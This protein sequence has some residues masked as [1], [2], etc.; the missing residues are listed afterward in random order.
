MNCGKRF[1]KL[2]SNNKSVCRKNQQRLE[3]VNVKPIVSYPRHWP[4]STDLLFDVIMFFNIATLLH[5]IATN[6]R[7]ANF[8]AKNSSLALL[9]EK[10]T[11]HV[12]NLSIGSAGFGVHNEKML[13]VQYYDV[14][15]IMAPTPIYPIPFDQ[16]IGF[17]NIFLSVDSF[18]A[19]E[20]QI[21]NAQTTKICPII[22]RKV[23]FLK[24]TLNYFCN[25][26]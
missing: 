4:L 17:R 21:S 11:R 10:G 23:I 20:H 22:T 5:L 25:S 26:N 13:A 12:E 6:R 9:Y 18:P 24:K 3:L 16:I 8:C 7:F 15:W 1:S 2:A 14:N 19:D